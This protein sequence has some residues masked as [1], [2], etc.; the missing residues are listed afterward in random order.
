MTNQHLQQLREI[1]NKHTGEWKAG[2]NDLVVEQIMQLFQTE[3]AK[4][5][6]R[7]LAALETMEVPYLYDSNG[8]WLDDKEPKAKIRIVT[9]EV[10]HKVRKVIEDA[11][12]N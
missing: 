2:R 8:D 6:Q 1:V 3:L 4:E 11:P 7:L 9:N 10:I 12:T 5:R